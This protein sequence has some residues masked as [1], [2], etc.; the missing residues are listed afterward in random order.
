MLFLSFTKKYIIALSLLALL[1]L[2]AYSNLNY[3]IK[4][5]SN[6]SKIINISGKQR[7]LSQRINNSLISFNFEKFIYNLNQME[8]AHNYLTSLAMSNDI[9][10]FYYQNPNALDKS[11][12]EFLFNGKKIDK[13]KKDSDEIKYIIN[14]AESLLEKFDK[15]T[16]LYQKESEAKIAQSEYFY[17]FILLLSLLI[18][19]LIGFFIF[20]PVNRQFEERTNQLIYEKDYSN[21][22]IESNTNA[23]IAI[24]KDLKVK[25][26]NKAA[27]IMFGYSKEEIIGKDSLLKLVPQKYIQ[28]HQ[29]AIKE[30]FETGKFKHNGENIELEAIR[31]NG[32][33][34]PIKISFGKNSNE[35]KHEKIVVANIQDMSVEKEKAKLLKVNEKI[36]KD[37][38]ESN[39]SIIFL[40]NPLDGNII[41]ANQSALD[42][43]GYEKEKFFTLNIVDINIL[44]KDNIK[45]KMDLALKNKQSNF[46]FVH[47]LANGELKNV[48]VNSTPTLYKEQIVLYVTIIDM[49]EEYKAKDKLLSLE[50]EFNDFFELS[51]NLHI[52]ASS[53]REILQINKACE[54]ILGY[55]KEE[56]HTSL[57]LKLLHPHDIEK[58]IHEMQK[59]DRGE[60][61]YYFENR[62][63]HKDGHYIDLAWYA[64]KNINTG[65]IYASA[66]NISDKKQIEKE[67]QKQSELLQQQSKM[68]AMG[69][70]IESIAHQWRQP[71]SLI[72]TVSTGLKFKK[73]MNVVEDGDIE[74][75]MD[76]IN[77]S[78]QYLS[79]TIDDFRDFF[80]ISKE[81]KD[82]LLESA[83]EKTFKLVNAQLSKA[84]I[85]VQKNIKEITIFGYE[86]E[87]VQVLIN[88]LNNA[89][90]EFK[91]KA[92][93]VKLIIIDTIIKGNFLEIHIKDNA[94][95]IPDDIIERIFE[96]HF[97]TK[98]DTTGTGIGLY[99][100]KM[101]IEEH[102][103]GKII[104]CN[105][106]FEFEENSYVGA[107]FIITLP[108]LNIK[109]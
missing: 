36:Y 107:L 77:N 72:S 70:M 104:A 4:E 10:N 97:T 8:S 13:D 23:I 94:G 30:H 100:S 71:L 74:T 40:L 28:L 80:K 67:K 62:Y 81:K 12:K 105:T 31:K 39:K 88:I 7:M 69:E 78:V 92:Q 86:N 29:K 84:N 47:K 54:T 96:S 64:I 53:Q 63:K 5:Q 18:L 68:A 48:R 44:S 21:I 52:I 27:E 51:I 15:I 55:K 108:L 45:E 93:P 75:N 49:T 11:V 101:I 25:T 85:Q 98:A 59:L 38:F 83:F 32:E 79:Q 65:I 61:V 42:F 103:E 58:T 60:V 102:M 50:Q 2:L 3:L 90:D 22:V 43:Y 34:F 33:I 89:A 109:E 73:I 9:K 99:M 106:N 76:S 35:T 82:F 26:F 57:F 20:R 37:L 6:D 41:S 46:D 19:F 24:G 91:R 1:S 56:L 14:N 87:L 16:L 17:K 95:G 66:Q